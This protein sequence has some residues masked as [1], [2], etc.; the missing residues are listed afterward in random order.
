MKAILNRL[1]LS[2][3]KSSEIYVEVYR[4]DVELLIK[5]HRK[6]VQEIRGKQMYLNP[7]LSD[8]AILDEIIWSLKTSNVSDLLIVNR[9]VVDL[10]QFLETGRPRS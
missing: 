1:E 3:D 8:W 7:S 2:L 9:V 5:K 6:I 10:K 4:P